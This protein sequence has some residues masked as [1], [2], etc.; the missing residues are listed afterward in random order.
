[1]DPK[2]GGG[3]LLIAYTEYSFNSSAFLTKKDNKQLTGNKKRSSCAS[4]SESRQSHT[5]VLQI[6]RYVVA[7]ILV[8]RTLFEA[9]VSIR[10]MSHTPRS[11]AETKKG[12]QKNNRNLFHHPFRVV[13]SYGTSLY[14]GQSSSSPPHP[15][16]APDVEQ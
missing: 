16:R 9:V 4:P 7:T 13:N 12:L 14:D 6:Y 5:R 2:S 15:N 3:G 11:I 8:P 1:M 10:H